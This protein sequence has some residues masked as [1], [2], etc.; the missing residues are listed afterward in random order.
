MRSTRGSRFRGVSKNGPKWQVM[1]VK[2]DLKK[3]LG[4]VQTE[5]KA[6]R[7]YD[8]Y[9]F[10]IWGVKVRTDIKISVMNVNRPRRISH[11]HGKVQ[12]NC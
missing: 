10:C 7:F 11:I 4:S 3:Y 6:G 2:G 1:L 12:S 8:K 5:E 9:A